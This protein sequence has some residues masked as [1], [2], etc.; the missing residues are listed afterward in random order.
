M[1]DDRKHLRARVLP[2][3]SASEHEQSWR[4]LLTKSAFMDIV[5]ACNAQESE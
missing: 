4:M 2:K 1:I 5:A 3:F